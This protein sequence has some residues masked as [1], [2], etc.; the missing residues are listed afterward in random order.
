MNVHNGRPY[1]REYERTEV[2]VKAR[3]MDGG[4]WLDCT[5]VNISASGAKLRSSSNYYQ[6]ETVRLRIGNF[7]EFGG[8]VSWHNSQN[9]GIK[10]THDPLEMADVLMGLA[11][12]G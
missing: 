11:V 3:I 5:I 9:V 8:V 6:G 12:Y 10:F 7:G 4:H 2:L 1:V